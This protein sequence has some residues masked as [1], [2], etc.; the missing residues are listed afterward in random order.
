[1]KSIKHINYRPYPDRKPYQDALTFTDQSNFPTFAS[2][3]LQSSR[4][5][6]I[7]HATLNNPRAPTLAAVYAAPAIE[8]VRLSLKR[9]IDKAAWQESFGKFEEALKIAEG[10]H[11]HVTGWV[12]EEEYDYFIQ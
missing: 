3:I 4:T 12:V 11:A 8:L 10:Y 1:M 6:S 2:T 9:G 7:Y 5:P